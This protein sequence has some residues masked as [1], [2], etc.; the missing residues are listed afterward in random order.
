MLEIDFVAIGTD[1]ANDQ[2]LTEKH[3]DHALRGD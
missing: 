1:L 3:R 2:P